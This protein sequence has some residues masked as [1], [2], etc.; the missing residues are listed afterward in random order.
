M[1]LRSDRYFFV[2]VAVVWF[3]LSGCSPMVFTAGAGPLDTIGSFFDDLG[4]SISQTTRRITGEP[5]G[6]RSAPVSA[7][8]DGF[9]LKIE[10]STLVPT[11]VYRGEQVTLILRYLIGGAPE[12]GVTVREKS[13][14][15]SEGKELKVLKDESS[16]KENGTWENTLSFAV[17]A[18]AKPGKYAVTLQVSAQ[19]KTRNVRHSFTVR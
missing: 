1:S 3:L 11:V 5:S 8:S 18:S 15:S 7:P 4:R 6:R 17:P 16:E 13:A 2:L 14:L 19:G 9:I 10:R 12:Q